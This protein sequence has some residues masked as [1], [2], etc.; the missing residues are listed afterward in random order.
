MSQMSVLKTT[1]DLTDKNVLQTALTAM[2]TMFPGMTTTVRGNDI[3]VHWVGIQQYRKQN[4][5]FKWTGKLFEP[6]GDSYNTGGN[7]D[8]VMNA[9]PVHYRRAVAKSVM[10]KYGSCITSEIKGGIR[11]RV[12][13]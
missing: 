3:L 9:V 10:G 11:L 4:L 7:L 1:V 2:A 8:R 6:I 5:T 13:R 12:H